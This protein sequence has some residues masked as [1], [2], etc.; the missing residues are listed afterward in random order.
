MLRLVRG[1]QSLT[2]PTVD[3]LDN[4]IGQGGLLLVV[5]HLFAVPVLVL[6]VELEKSNN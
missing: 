5:S 3:W 6:W 2:V 1:T 4:L